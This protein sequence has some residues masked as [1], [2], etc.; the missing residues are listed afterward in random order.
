MVV[1][2][3]AEMLIR[4]NGREGCKKFFLHPFSGIEILEWLVQVNNY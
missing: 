2:I 1:I 3:V 4:G